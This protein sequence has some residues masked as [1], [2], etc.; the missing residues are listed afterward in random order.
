MMVMSRRNSATI[1]VEETRPMKKTLTLMIST[2]AVAALLLG[3]AATAG[4]TPTKTKSCSGC[5][6]RSTAIKV[7]V[8]KSSATTSTVT[9]KVKVTGGSGTTAW[10]VL[11]GGKNLAR[12]RASTGTFKVALGKT[13]RVWAYKG[14]KSNYKATMT[15]K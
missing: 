14:G 8:T 1:P 7:A 10:A 13:F 11:S 4:A 9:Y 5:H 12:K 15:A 2:V 3:T 6:S